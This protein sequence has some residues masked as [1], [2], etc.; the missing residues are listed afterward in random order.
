MKKTKAA[1]AKST[2]AVRA[3]GWSNILSGIGTT[4]DR[5]LASTFG[6]E[7]LDYGT[8]QT[9]YRGNDIA[10]RIIDEEPGALGR[11]WLKVQVG[12]DADATSRVKQAM[13]DLKVR[14]EIEKAMKWARAYGGS[15]MLLGANDGVRD[16]RLPLVETS[17]RSVDWLTVLD[18]SE[19]QAQSWYENPRS[20]RYG[21]PKTYRIVPKLVGDVPAADLQ[22][23]EV[24]ESRLIPFQ[25]VVVDRDQLRSGQFPGWG[26]SVLQR[27]HA[28][29]RD[30]DMGWDSVAI[31]L[32]EFAVATYGIEGL[33]NLVATR[34]DAVVK[35]RVELIMQQKSTLR[36]VLMDA[37]ETFKR[38][39][40]PLSG[41]ADILDRFCKRMAAAAGMPVTVMMG[42]SPA[43]LAATGAMEVRNWYD[44]IAAGRQR[45][46][47]A[48]MERLLEVL[49]AAKA[50]PT[51]GVVPDDWSLEYNPLWQLNAMEEADLRS[52]QASTDKAYV[53]MGAV[54]PEEVAISRFPKEGYNAGRMVVD[55]E[56]REA[57]LSKMTEEDL[58]PEPAPA[59]QPPKPEQPGDP[60]AREDFDPDQERDEKGMWTKGAGASVDHAGQAKIRNEKA[61]SLRTKAEAIRK[62][63]NSQSEE[64]LD[65]DFA[66]DTHRD[67]AKN[68]EA[69]M[70][71]NAASAAAAERPFDHAAHEAAASAHEEAAR[72]WR[73][74]GTKETVGLSSEHLKFADSHRKASARA[75]AK[76]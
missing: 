71:A 6:T 25:G 22:N 59:L 49:F 28:I 11:A 13:E 17:I 55:L 73:Y 47:G 3:D 40:V 62:R 38:E 24:H 9:L 7:Q 60:K 43:G 4:R 44:R 75:K 41:V 1:S 56:L 29:L 27:P 8:L 21:E 46:L 32:T 16:L 23:M 72:G 33:A 5:R 34:Q 54:T 30:F 31:L 66:A 18:A 2:P 45:T 36:G 26:D 64:D 50:G 74:T 35:K 53:D 67:I 69:T 19:I 51:N 10:A 65:V 76:G 14:D 63:G 42:D 57:V 48:P 39:T 61:A 12:D 52:K 68:H 20:K 37:K 70:K 58:K 15:A